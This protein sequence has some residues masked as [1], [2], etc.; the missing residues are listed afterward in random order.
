MIANPL[1]LI[2]NALSDVT[3]ADLFEMRTNALQ[4]ETEPDRIREDAFTAA[5]FAARARRQ[6]M[7]CEVNQVQVRMA[8]ALEYMEGPPKTRHPLSASAAEQAAGR[9]G[10][11]LGTKEATADAWMVAA[12]AAAIARDLAALAQLPDLSH[13]MEPANV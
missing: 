7:A 13:V 9:D 1:H 2:N 5:V 10:E 12:V 3:L 4:V 6:A 8:L 11:Y